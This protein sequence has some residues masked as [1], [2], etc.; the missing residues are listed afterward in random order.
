MFRRILA[1]FGFAAL[2]AAV[3][4]LITG[5]LVFIAHIFL[6]LGDVS[7]LSLVSGAFAAS[8]YFTLVNATKKARQL[9]KQRKQR[10]ADGQTSAVEGSA[11]MPTGSAFLSTGSKESA[12]D[13]FAELNYGD[14][15]VP[16]ETKRASRR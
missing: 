1:F 13:I 14:F 5:G 12:K 4:A 9:R 6:P 15:Q 3:V 11:G 16:Q 7:Y 8:L 2:K 10:E